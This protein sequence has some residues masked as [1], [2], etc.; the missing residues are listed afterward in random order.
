MV[1]NGLPKPREVWLR[2]HKRLRLAAHHDGKRGVPRPNVAAGDGR[3]K[4]RGSQFR[5]ARSEAARGGWFRS[6]EIDKNRRLRESFKDP[7]RAKGHVVEFVR[8]ADIEA[9]K[10]CVARGLRWS[11]SPNRAFGQQGF[12]FRTCARVNN[13]AASRAQQMSGHRSPHDAGTDP[14]N[15]TTLQ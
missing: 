13:H 4:R 11:F 12:C 10:V 14:A 3:I 8:H 1:H 6:S 2:F 5:S 9:D 15:A 7:A